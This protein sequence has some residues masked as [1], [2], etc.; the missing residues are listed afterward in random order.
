MKPTYALTLHKTY[1]EKG[2]FNLGVAVERYIAS[3]DCDVTIFVG[4]T[5]RSIAGTMSRKP[6]LN[7]TPRIY[8]RSELRNWFMANHDVLDKVVVMIES[9][10][11]L[12]IKEN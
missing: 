5:R 11:T 9:P 6:N 10:D 2:F 3:E 12:W 4:D 7:G 8:G 1:Y